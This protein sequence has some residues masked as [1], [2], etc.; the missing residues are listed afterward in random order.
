[1]GA[2]TLGSAD[3]IDG[4][5]GIDTLNLYATQD[6][7]RELVGSVQNIELINIVGSD[8]IGSSL[9]EA[10][11]ELIAQRQDE[12]AAAEQALEDAIAARSD[13]LAERS[14]AQAEFSDDT[15]A[16]ADLM[17]ALNGVAD[18]NPYVYGEDVGVSD[19]N[20]D[21][22]A[23][24]QASIYNQALSIINASSADA[25]MK[26]A[27]L[28]ALAAT[29]Q[30]ATADDGINQDGAYRAD[31]LSAIE[32]ALDGILFADSDDIAALSD[33]IAALNTEIGDSDDSDDGDLYGDVYAAEQ[34]LSDALEEELNGQID[35]EFFAGSTDITIDGVYTD[36]FNVDGQTIT[37]NAGEDGVVNSVGYN[38]GV[39]EANI[40]LDATAGKITVDSESDDLET[41]NLSGTT[42]A[43]DD[44]IALIDGSGEDTIATLN[45]ALTTETTGED[46]VEVDV[47][48]MDALDTIDASAST[49]NIE[50]SEEDVHNFTGSAGNDLDVDLR[51]TAT[52]DDDTWTAD[53]GTGDDEVFVNVDGTITITAVVDVTTGEGDD[54]VELRV[55]EDV[56]FNIDGGAGDD[57]VVLKGGNFDAYTEYDLAGVNGGEGADTLTIDV[58]GDDSD[59]T[60]FAFAGIADTAVINALADSGS[61]ETLAFEDATGDWDQR[62]DASRL[63]NFSTLEF[64]SDD[65]R[66]VVEN[67]DDDQTLVARYDADLSASAIDYD[68]EDDGNDVAGD[69]TVVVKQGW[70]DLILRADHADITVE[71]DGYVYLGYTQTDSDLDS[72][73]INL[74]ATVDA[75]G[76]LD[77]MAE[78]YVYIDNLG[79]GFD[80]LTINGTGYAVVDV[81]G[82][83]ASETRE[84]ITVDASGMTSL[85]SGKDGDFENTSLVYFGQDDIAEMLIV[86]GGVN[87]IEVESRVGTYDADTDSYSL[88]DT[89]EGLDFSAGTDDTLSFG[90]LDFTP[91]EF[92]AFQGIGFTSLKNAVETVAALETDSIVFQYDG[93]TYIFAEQSG[94][95]NG[96]GSVEADDMLIKLVGNYD[97]EDVVAAINVPM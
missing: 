74:N 84:L 76:G 87:D 35:A 63:D 47:D 66:N 46:S 28:A 25:E 78:A 94:E 21:E 14:A 23:G 49:S 72:A 11:L 37:M 97:L 64:R 96:E 24:D 13:A 6:H 95:I 68:F 39:T 59:D 44:Y 12:L 22:E 43:G 48:G 92:V 8:F 18:P 32:S 50:W 70:S 62:L 82:I 34:A 85:M 51:G 2:T 4:G 69:L 20:E 3:A 38:P 86:G 61:F 29:N 67:A 60:D 19:T 90:W 42:S 33:E 73:T 17:T 91:E 54:V 80:T 26:A 36:I 9:T 53:T 30:Y 45:V 1:M 7:N 83:D 58:W 16:S 40:V 89:I 71:E 57:E 10:D 55:R 31:V 93:A 88:M 77:D 65:N 56:E 52:S 27:A 81:S 41:L 5:D 75:D 15:S 79:A